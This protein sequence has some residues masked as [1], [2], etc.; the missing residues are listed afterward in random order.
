MDPDSAQ[1]KYYGFGFQENWLSANMKKIKYFDSQPKR[2]DR[3]MDATKY[4]FYYYVSHQL[5]LIIGKII[6]LIS[7]NGQNIFHTYLQFTRK[8]IQGFFYFF[9]FMISE[10]SSY[11]LALKVLQKLKQVVFTLI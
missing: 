8:K 10:T 3:Q 4:I 2:A 9:I 6:I 1:K 7:C 11:L 5:H